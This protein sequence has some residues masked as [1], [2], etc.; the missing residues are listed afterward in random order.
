MKMRNYLEFQ[1]ENPK[2]WRQ[3]LDTIFPQ[4]LPLRA[5]WQ[6][7][8]EILTVLNQLGAAPGV[9]YTFLPPWIGQVSRLH[10]ESFGDEQTRY[11]CYFRLE[12]QEIPALPESP[13]TREDYYQ[14]LT[15]IAPGL[16]EP[17]SAWD[18][19]YEEGCE[20][21]PGARLIVRALRGSL[22]IFAKFS[23]YNRLS[24][25]T[26]A[27]HERLGGEGFRARVQLLRERTL[28]NP[29]ITFEQ[30][31]ALLVNGDPLAGS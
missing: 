8:A 3:L 11:W 6:D 16:Y 7:P 14:Y 22:V 13:T 17:T 29:S 28:V 31:D 30:L 20:L 4:G 25:S 24:H 15:E 10:F 21:A 23:L 12:W 9:H 18:N 27:I 2:E 26:D 1:Q 19:R 5:Q